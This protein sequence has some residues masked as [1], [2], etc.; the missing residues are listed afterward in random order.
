MLHPHLF[1]YNKITFLLTL[2]V[3]ISPS[4]R[5]KLTLQEDRVYGSQL[6]RPGILPGCHL[7]LTSVYPLPF[8]LFPG[9]RKCLLAHCPKGAGQEDLASPSISGFPHSPSR[10]ATSSSSRPHPVL[11]KPC[12][13]SL[14]LWGFKALHTS[15][16]LRDLWKKDCGCL[17]GGAFHMP[18]SIAEKV[19]DI[20]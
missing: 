19:T 5:V 3:T 6:E 2:K 1:K 15:P 16:R 8:P 14:T 18:M 7:V 11:G 10:D 13:C 4:F 12:V 17:T 9:N 20:D